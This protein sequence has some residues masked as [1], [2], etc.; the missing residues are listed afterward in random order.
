MNSRLLV[1]NISIF[2]LRNRTRKRCTR[3][4]TPALSFKSCVKST[5]HTQRLSFLPFF[6][7][8]TRQHNSY[9]QVYASLLTSANTHARTRMHKSINVVRGYAFHV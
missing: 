1:D 3:K 8:L 7:L 2:Y 4:Q 6:F 5:V 9:M